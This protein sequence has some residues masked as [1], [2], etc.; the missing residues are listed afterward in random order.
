M[1][2]QEIACQVN[3]SKEAGKGLYN[4]IMIPWLKLHK[5]TL[6]YSK[7]QFLIASEIHLSTHKTEQTVYPST[8]HVL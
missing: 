8:L 3:E 5:N 6:N 1:S 7:L 4:R 2:L